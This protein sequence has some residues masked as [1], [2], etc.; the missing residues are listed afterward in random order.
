MAATAEDRKHLSGL[1]LLRIRRTKRRLRA[2]LGKFTGGETTKAALREGVRAHL[3]A[4][5]AEAGYLGRNLAGAD[6]PF[7]ADDQA[8]GESVASEQMPYFDGFVAD[9]EAGRYTDEAGAFSEDAIGARSDLYGGA[10]LGTAN[11][12]WANVLPAETIFTWELGG[13][14]NCET[15]PVLAADSPYTQ[16]TLPG[17]PGDPGICECGANCRCTLVTQDGETSFVLDEE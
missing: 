12:V 7:G 11:G 6:D 14:N 9:I 2:D 17:V 3:G 15:C 16:E 4:A 5:H 8:L 13:V 10:L 1:L